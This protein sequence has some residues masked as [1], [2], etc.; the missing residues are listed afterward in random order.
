MNIKDT[1]KLTLTKHH[2]KLINI[3]LILLFIPILFSCSSKWEYTKNPIII[4]YKGKES[5]IYPH[6]YEKYSKYHGG[7]FASDICI[8]F[9][10]SM[11]NDRVKVFNTINGYVFDFVINENNNNNVS[12][13]I[14]L[15]S[16]SSRHQITLNNS[17]FEIEPDTYA[18]YTFLIIKKRNNKY[19]F[20]FTNKINYKLKEKQLIMKRSYNYPELR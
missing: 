2:I 7:L 6:L 8:I 16:A 9:E 4:K 11:I 13:L 20:T 14:Y 12:K 5:I 18:K 10:N 15:P 17:S 1:M 19:I 3:K